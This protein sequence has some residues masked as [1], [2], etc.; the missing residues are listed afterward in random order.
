MS[1][2]EWFGSCASQCSSFLRDIVQGRSSMRQVLATMQ[3]KIRCW[4]V[5]MLSFVSGH[6]LELYVL[7]AVTCAWL[8]TPTESIPTI[9]GQN[10]LLSYRSSL[11]STYR[12]TRYLRQGGICPKPKCRAIQSFVHMGRG[13]SQR[14]DQRSYHPPAKEKSCQRASILCPHGMGLITGKRF[15]AVRMCG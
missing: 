6:P 9:F 12:A 7:A 10:C 4:S 5:G 1:G 8:A 11:R 14:A 13:L 15:G 2:K 3:T